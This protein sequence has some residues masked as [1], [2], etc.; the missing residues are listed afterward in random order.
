MNSTLIALALAFTAATACAAESPAAE[1]P[2]KRLEYFVG[3]WKESGESR[4]DSN[5]E[6]GKLS[7]NE[8]CEWQ[9]GHAA[10]LCRETTRDASGTVDASYLIGYDPVSKTYVLRGF[11]NTGMTLT[12]TGTI[13]QDTWTWIGLSNSAAGSMSMRFTFDLAH[14]PG[15]TMTVEF[16]DK[17][18][19]WVKAAAIDY[20][21]AK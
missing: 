9:A 17:E 11:D 15:R 19:K 16:A 6:F 2:A 10:V 20:S 13:D 12:A 8:T 1:S 21:K 7:G 18:G 14:R 3:T 5:Q 4:A